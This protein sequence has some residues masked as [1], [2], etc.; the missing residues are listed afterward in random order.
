MPAYQGGLSDAAAVTAQCDDC[1]HRRK[2]AGKAL[3]DLACRYGVR[4]VEALGNRLRCQPCDNRGGVGDNVT[5]WTT[6]RVPIALEQR[7]A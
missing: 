5:I 6:W 7:R 2:W 1:G 3:D 4:T